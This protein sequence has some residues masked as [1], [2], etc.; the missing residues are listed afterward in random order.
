MC[1]I[2]GRPEICTH[3]HCSVFYLEFAMRSANYQQLQQAQQEARINTINDHQFNVISS[4]L[5]QQNTVLLEILSSGGKCIDTVDGILNDLKSAAKETRPTTYQDFVIE[6]D[7]DPNI[8]FEWFAANKEFEYSLE[9]Q[10]E[11]PETVFKERG[12]SLTLILKNKFGGP[13][14]LHSHRR[15]KAYLFT[16]EKHPRCLKLNIAGKK[17]LRGTTETETKE[18]GVVHF[19]SLV[20]NEV[21]SHYTNGC[22]NLVI[23][24]ISSISV[25]PIVINNLVVR[26]RKLG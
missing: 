4:V 20:I 1:L 26:A 21:S 3:Q 19:D 14:F 18:G 8:V 5:D 22:F 16:Q 15:Y 25:R 11:L 23:A 17:I 7:F 24:N 6:N 2:S 10:Q 9:N 12:F 13:V